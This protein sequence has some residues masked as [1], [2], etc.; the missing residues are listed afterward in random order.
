MH[1][2]NW[3]WPVNLASLIMRAWCCAL[4]IGQ[5]SCSLTRTA[6]KPQRTA[7]IMLEYYKTGGFAGIED[8]L[9]IHEDGTVYFQ[10]SISG[11][12]EHDFKGRLE[13]KQ[14][15]EVVALAE[16]ADIFSLQAEYKEESQPFDAFSYQLTYKRASREK[17]ITVDSI[18]KAPPHL[19]LLFNRLEAMTQDLLAK[20]A[21]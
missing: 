8:M 3:G 19:Q 5:A 18:S 4:I 21:K 16:Q 7:T 11:T 12:P 1:W 13:T 15:Q 6:D 17:T 9:T 14:L 20:A 2:E 10:R